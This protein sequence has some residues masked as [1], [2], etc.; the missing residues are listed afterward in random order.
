MRIIPL[1]ILNLKHL[2]DLLREVPYSSTLIVFTKGN[3]K[4][5]NDIVIAPGHSTAILGPASLF[6]SSGRRL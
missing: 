4:I 1:G 6:G 2:K 5:G 3:I